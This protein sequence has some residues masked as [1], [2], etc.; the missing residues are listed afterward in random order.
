MRVIRNPLLA[1]TPLLMVAGLLIA[2]GVASAQ[3][4]EQGLL[5]AIKYRPIPTGAVIE[6]Q[7]LDNSDEN[8]ELVAILEDALRT[9]GHM[10]SDHGVLVMT[11]ETRDEIGAWSTSGSD[12]VI[13]FQ[14]QQGSGGTDDIDLRVNLFDSETGGLLSNSQSNPTTIVTP[15][16][17]VIDVT[18]DSRED[19]KR[20]WQGWITA[21][22]SHAGNQSLKHRMIPALANAY[23][24][25]IDRQT[26]TL[27]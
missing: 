4:G 25:T 5:N 27:P 9:Q 7:S 16:R 22:L 26:V 24:M 19:G 15:S 23:G 1:F 10:V 14:T 11:I 20:L 17:Y 18:V 6:V 8:L 21:D 12:S 2:A 13:A 3:S